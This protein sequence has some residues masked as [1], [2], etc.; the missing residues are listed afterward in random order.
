MTRSGIVTSIHRTATLF[1]LIVGVATVHAQTPNT[2]PPGAPSGT[3]TP[4]VLPNNNPVTPTPATTAQPS[5]R[6]GTSRGAI[7]RPIGTPSPNQQQ[8][9]AAYAPAAAAG[10]SA[11][12]PWIVKLVPHNL[13]FRVGQCAP[14]S[15][16]LLD[17]SGRDTPRAPNGWRVSIADF[18]MTVVTASGASVVGQYNGAS[19]WSAC[20]CP[21]VPPGT[22][23]TITATYPSRAIAAGSRVPG[24]AFQST[25]VLPPVAFA[26][27]GTGNPSACASLPPTTTVAMNP[28]PGS[29]GSTG[30]GNGAVPVA[31]GTNGG[32][33]IPPTV[34]V[35]QGAVP[36][37]AQP[38]PAT[39]PA[40]SNGLAGATLTPVYFAPAQVSVT[41]TPAEAHVTWSQAASANQYTVTRWKESDPNCCRATSPALPASS[42]GWTDLV[43]WTGP[44]LYRV[45]ATFPD[46]SQQYTDAR[47]V[48]PEPQAPTGFTAQQTAPG[49]V[50]LS[51]QPVRDASYYLLGGPPGNT[52]IRVDG[53]S[54][55]RTGVPAGSQTW[56]V[57]TNY[58]SSAGPQQGST[59]ANTTLAVSSPVSAGANGTV[60][61]G[62][63]G[64]TGGSGAAPA[65]PA[66]T[67]PNIISGNYRVVATG[68]RVLH[69]TKDDMFSRDG[70]YDEVYGA[71]IMLHYD[72]MTSALLDKDLGRTK[73]IGDTNHLPGRVKGGTASADGGLAAGDV[74][75][76]VADPSKLYGAQPT[77]YSFPYL[78]WTGTLTNER[79]AVIILPTIWE[80]DGQPA[81]YDNWFAHEIADS[82]RIWSDAGVQR[83]LTADVLGVTMPP[84]TPQSSG[85]P[86]FRA[87]SLFEMTFFGSGIETLF[88]MGSY[89]RPI[90]ATHSGVFPTL[91]RRAIVIT[92]EIIE[93]TLNKPPIA[94]PVSTGMLGTVSNLF[95]TMPNGGMPYGTI[96]VPLFDGPGNDL[97]GQYILYITVER[98]P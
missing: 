84:G 34:T 5:G 53:T 91:P 12:A 19:N 11:A 49:T 68:F 61:A 14:V 67:A 18:D 26:A 72:R 98:I 70:K 76:A 60:A 57:A 71:F 16:E 22:V 10:P 75:P 74:F 35:A 97:Q 93:S 46:G 90:G 56:M 59:F 87:D 77:N 20:V 55:V 92:R 94:A 30:A 40:S 28:P 95:T 64:T 86:S 31:A 88:G 81:G 2:R 48:Y 58:Q 32:T 89:D 54:A 8:A 79:D 1:A 27:A 38:V 9:L 80:Y 63:S 96:A 7:V 82:P 17:A 47:Y 78:I 21:D 73:V 41:G 23:A 62:G 50:T 13:P 15:I 51:W 42:T 29:S 24:V 65:A 33:A 3:T 36:T 52:A 45:T 25:M 37:Q 83:A 43:Q 6:S 44:W 85:W 39:A 4:A 66:A 69:E